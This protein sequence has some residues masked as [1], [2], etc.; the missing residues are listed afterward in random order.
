VNKQT[1][2]PKPRPQADEDRPIRSIGQVIEDHLEEIVGSETAAR[3]RAEKGD[4][5]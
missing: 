2:Q 1:P 4:R 3:L 5:K